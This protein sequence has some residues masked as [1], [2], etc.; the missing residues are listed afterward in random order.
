M[1]NFYTEGIVHSKT[2]STPLRQILVD[3][4]SV[5]N[6]IPNVVARQCGLPFC[7][8]DDLQIRTATGATL[9]I[10]YYT[11]FDI[12]VAGCTANIRAY[13]IP[14]ATTYTLLLGRRW[15]KPVDLIGHYGPGTYTIV[16]AKGER[17]AIPECTPN[18]GGREPSIVEIVP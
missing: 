9:D 7:Q 17:K 18:T 2:E 3:G 8:N 5:V 10:H 4:G 12:N 15:M 14:M 11:K 13:I 16:D 6:L 1:V